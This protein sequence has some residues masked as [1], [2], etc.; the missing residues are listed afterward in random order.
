MNPHAQPG[1][2]SFKYLPGPRSPQ[3]SKVKGSKENGKFPEFNLSY[4]ICY[5]NKD[6]LEMV[7]GSA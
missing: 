4:K 3:R 7:F 1:D 2:R 6:H 5:S